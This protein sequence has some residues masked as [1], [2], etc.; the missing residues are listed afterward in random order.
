[1]L[2][3]PPHV[4]VRWIAI[5]IVTVGIAR[6]AMEVHAEEPEEWRAA[7]GQCTASVS[8]ELG[9]CGSCSGAWKKI[10]R[11]AAHNL[12]P[13]MPQWII[14]TCVWSIDNRTANARPG[15]DRVAPVLAC[16]TQRPAR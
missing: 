12:V 4:V 1:M 8:K 11:C 10:S 15:F 3:Q 16:V 14:D 6:C 5:F 13:H 2:I 9:G 7:A